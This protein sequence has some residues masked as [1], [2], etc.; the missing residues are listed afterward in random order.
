[1]QDIRKHDKDTGSVEVQVAQL[2]QEIKRLTEHFN[3]FPK[4]ANSKRGLLKKVG[5][6]NR[7][8]KYLQR[9]NE[10]VYTQLLERLQIRG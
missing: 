4:D 3:A 1:M 10:A 9:K 6:R 2:T 7:F 8:L 5:Q